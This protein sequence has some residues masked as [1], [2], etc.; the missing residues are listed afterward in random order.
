MQNIIL[1]GMP[2]SG[3][4]TVG[5]LVAKALG[6]EFVDTDAV[7]KERYGDIPTI[8]AKHGEEYFR[9]VE[10]EVLRDVGKLSGKV[11]STGGGVVKNEIN[12]KALS[13]NGKV[14]YI[15]TGEKSHFQIDNQNYSYLTDIVEV[16][17][18]ALS[19]EGKEEY[20]FDFKSV[21][22]S[23]DINI[24]KLLD[25]VDFYDKDTSKKIEVIKDNNG[26]PKVNLYFKVEGLEEIDISLSHCKEYAVA[27]VVAV[28]K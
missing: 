21:I 18:A 5:K 13:L 10:S 20:D 14:I 22:G 27:Q 1:I 2:G 25:S 19:A 12:M 9:K 6:R 7:I 23:I 24:P 11:I 4:S 16:D 3:K 17:Y 28:F 15:Q 8:F 26:R